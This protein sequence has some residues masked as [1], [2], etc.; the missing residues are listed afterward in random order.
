MTHPREGDLSA[1][2]GLPHR[3]LDHDDLDVLEL[4]LGGALPALPPLAAIPDDIDVVLTDGERT[5]LARLLPG[6]RVPRRMRP[7]AR[8][9]GPQWDPAVRRLAAEVRAQVRRE[10]GDAPVLAVVIDDVPTRADVQAVLGIVGSPGIAALLCVVAVARRPRPRGQVGWAGLTR[11]GLAMADL[12][13]SSHPGLPVI[14]LVVPWPDTD[15]G[16]HA[17][18]GPLPGG[19]APD[20]GAVLASYGASTVVR[21]REVRSPEEHERVAALPGAFEREVRALY[22][23]A[24]ALEVLRAHRAVSRR[25]A[26]V[27]FSGLSG[28]G[29]STIA[30]ALVDDLT[31]RGERGVTLLDGDEVR[32]HLSSELGF[33]ARSRETNIRRIAYVASLI[34]AH[35]GLAVAAPIAPFASSRHWARDVVRTRGEFVLVYVSTP[36]EVCEARDR[37]GLYARARAGLLPDFT[38][39][40]SPYEAPDDADIVIDTS[41]TGVAEAVRQ[42]RTVLERRLRE[43]EEPGT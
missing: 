10:V 13:A 20:L 25:G 34:A 42:I 40:S 6:T 19:A 18:A 17:G 9:E 15:R 4:V 8:A 37:K 30:R 41:Q 29:K 11:A 3:V 24:S 23:D 39:I 21:L 7:F 22:P 31:E 12:L 36:P 1:V 28:S 26:V 35:G 16:V 32:E 43:G 2:A 5:P 27:M 33:D 14:P 38:G